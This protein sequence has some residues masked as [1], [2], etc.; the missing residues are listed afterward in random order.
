[1]PMSQ[2]NETDP[3]VDTWLAQA[4]AWQDIL[5]ALRAL[6]R[7]SGLQ[8]TLKWGKPCYG[9][10]GANVAI[11]YSFKESAALGFFKGAL[12]HGPAEL[13]AA[14][15]ENSQAMR[16]ARFT[17]AQAVEQASEALSALLRDAIALEQA[18]IDVPFAPAAAQ[19]MP[20]E[21]TDRLAADAVL[22]TA[23]EALTPGRR[24]S[25]ALYLGQ[26]K[27]SATRLARLERCVPLILEGLGPNERG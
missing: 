10:N 8:E 7:Q 1:M 16:M 9:Y 26:A 23:F 19:P 6:A 17:T 15:G 13:L 14:P 11:L 18:G 22:R 12:L 20:Q 3:R 4:P 25:Y 24:R 21:L 5:T 27:Q 2:T